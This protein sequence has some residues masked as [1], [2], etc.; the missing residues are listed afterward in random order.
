MI[1][2]KTGKHKI[3]VT[4]ASGYV[5][6]MLVFELAKRE[7]VEMVFGLDVLPRPEFLD[8]LKKLSWLKTNT[9]DLSWI[10][11]MEE[12]Q[13]DIVIHTAW[14]IR[15]LYG[16]K[17]LQRKWNI[18]GSQRVFNFALNSPCVSRLIH[19]STVASYGAYPDN[20][21]EKFFKEEDLLRPSD[22]LYAEEKREVE[23][24]LKKI[25]LERGYKFN[26]KIYIVRP[27]SI[28][29]PRGRFGREKF[30][31]QSVLS[32]SIIKSKSVWYKLIGFLTSFTPI[33]EKW[34]RQFVHEDDVIEITMILAFEE[35]LG[36]YEVFN[37]APL[38]KPV[39]GKDMAL[40][41]GKK[42]VKIPPFL[43]RVIFFFLRH[44]S[45]GKIPTSRGGWKSYSYPI[46]VDGSK[47]TKVF[48]YKYKFESKDAFTK[49]EGKYAERYKNF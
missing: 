19:F 36:N 23:N 7:D 30:G 41:V 26:K 16:K 5:G 11:K 1:T 46:L 6:A 49:L 18:E 29:G 45:F 20:S 35:N 14:Q 44:L 9:K 13:P 42:A 25:V 2:G 15:E 43:I 22:Y 32:G 10:S 8:G 4:G 47:I 38:G 17:K 33:T 39:F 34:A 31:L 12:F 27:A 37:L 48:N 40:M 28:T 21:L 24:I 3:L